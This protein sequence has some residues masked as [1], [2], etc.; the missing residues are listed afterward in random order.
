VAIQDIHL[1]VQRPENYLGELEEVLRNR[2]NKPEISLDSIPK[3]NELIWGFKKGEM[4]VIGA[5]PSH[6]KSALAL[7][8]ARDAAEQGIPTLFISLEMVVIELLERLFCNVMHIENRSLTKGKYRDDPAMQKKFKTFCEIVKSMDMLITEGL[9]AKFTELNALLE[10]LDPC[11]SLVIVDYIQTIKTDQGFARDNTNEYVRAFRA[12]ALEKKFCG[13]LCSQIN[14]DAPNSSSK[15]PS[16]SQ[17]K[18]TG[19][20]EEHTDKCILCHWPYKYNTNEDSNKYQII[21]AKNRNGDTGMIDVHFEPSTY[22]YSE[23]KMPAMAKSVFPASR[24]NYNGYGGN[25]YVGNGN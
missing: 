11:P 3:L 21:V 10:T 17:L 24:L 15:L 19:V 6:G 20:L 16:M 1:K 8:I 2:S 23:Y 18:Q 25:K 4:V 7:Q 14:R 22:S 5:R 13:I 9:G 12:A